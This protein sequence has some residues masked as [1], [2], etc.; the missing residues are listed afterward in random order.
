MRR[1]GRLSVA[2]LLLL[3]VYPAAAV[4]QSPTPG[5]ESPRGSAAPTAAGGNLTIDVPDGA[6][7]AGT[8]V[9][10]VA[11]APADRPDELKSVPTTLAFFELQ[12]ADVSFSSPATVTRTVTFGEVGIDQYDPLF[13]GLIV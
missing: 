10:V 7:P 2:A 11:H 5:S 1:S 12:P 3:L 13:D 6:A 4:A 9:T 8:T